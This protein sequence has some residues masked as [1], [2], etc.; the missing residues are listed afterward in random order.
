MRFIFLA[1]TLIVSAIPPALA[2]DSLRCGSKLVR[3]GMSMEDVQEYCGSPS[4]SSIENQ[5][6]H[7]GN[8]VVGTTQIHTWHYDRG[9]GQRTAVLEF[10]QE[11]LRSIHYES[12]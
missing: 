12:K 3:I 8:R 10:D 2:D 7:S 1:I 11:K 4:S 5:N 9:A 6:V